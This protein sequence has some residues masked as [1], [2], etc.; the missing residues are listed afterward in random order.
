VWCAS[1][2]PPSLALNIASYDADS[3]AGGLGAAGRS[4]GGMVL[5][6]ILFLA[7]LAR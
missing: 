3:N 4:R 1:S 5:I 6:G 2:S 7:I